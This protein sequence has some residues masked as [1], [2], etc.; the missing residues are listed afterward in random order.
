MAR[1]AGQGEEEEE[2]RARAR[3]QEERCQA[4]MKR[5]RVTVRSPAQRP[6]R[7]VPASSGVFHKTMSEDKL[8]CVMLQGSFERGATE[9]P[10]RDEK[11]VI[12]KVGLF[13][14]A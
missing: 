3:Q 4:A 10:L 12:F 9:N 6:S 14:V 1:K 8:E 11:P 7:M 5:C 2:Y 13:L